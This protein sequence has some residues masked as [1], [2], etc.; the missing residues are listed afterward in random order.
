ME[1]TVEGT[2]RFIMT[3][4]GTPQ[5]QKNILGSQMFTQVPPHYR[6]SSPAHIRLSISRLSPGLEG[7]DLVPHVIRVMGGTFLVKI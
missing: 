1:S 6:R 3:S 2:K 5:I 4:D 7:E